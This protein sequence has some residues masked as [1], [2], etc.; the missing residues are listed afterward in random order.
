MQLYH[1]TTRDRAGAILREGFRDG[2]GSYGT[3][4]PWSG[5]WLADRPL[6][7][8]DTG[9]VSAD[10]ILAVSLDCEIDALSDY[11]WVE[12]GQSYREWLVP[13]DFV[14]KRT[15]AIVVLG[16]DMLTS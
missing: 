8:N 3:D 15:V 1:V 5:V 9:N 4:Q 10:T 13:A 11:E 12:K 7:S 2:A 6:D 14:N 16:T